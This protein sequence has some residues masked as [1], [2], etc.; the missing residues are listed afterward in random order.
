MKKSIVFG[1]LI[2]C[3]LLLITSC[4]QGS[5]NGETEA[6]GGLHNNGGPHSVY[7]PGISY[8]KEENVRGNNPLER[9]LVDMKSKYSNYYYNHYAREIPTEMDS[10]EYK[11]KFKKWYGEDGEGYQRYLDAGKQSDNSKTIFSE[12]EM[13]GGKGVLDGFEWL[14]SQCNEVGVYV[15][16]WND[17]EITDE[18]GLDFQ[19]ELI[20]KEATKIEYNVEGMFDG[21][22]TEIWLTYLDEEQNK[23]SI[24][25]LAKSRGYSFKKTKVVLKDRTLDAVVT[26]KTFLSTYWVFFKYDSIVVGVRYYN[27]N[28]DFDWFNELQFVVYQP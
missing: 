16:K 14:I 20:I 26:K 21:D 22:F 10:E 5:G 9:F 2:L 27:E 1:L 18:I 17:T 23:M 24:D 8:F 28:A 19:I 7:Q 3:I 25:K 12:L 6:T 13:Y 4:G 15:P 11:S